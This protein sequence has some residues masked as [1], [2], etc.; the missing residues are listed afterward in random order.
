MSKKMKKIIAAVISITF[1]L[2]SVGIVY[3]ADTHEKT[4]TAENTVSISA[5]NTINTSSSGKDE[6]VYVFAGADGSTNKIIVSDWLKNPDGESS[7]KD[8]SELKNIENVKGDETFSLSGKEVTWNADG[9]D[10]YYQGEISKE[11]PISMNIKYTLDGKEVSPKELAGKS[12]HVVIRYEYTNNQLEKVELNGKEQEVYVPFAVLTGMVLDNDIFKN[13]EVT[14]G[15]LINDGNRSAVVG[16]AFPSLQE[17]LKI[18]KDKFEIPDYFE[19][20]ADV[21]NFSLTNTVTLATNEVFNNISFSKSDELSNLSDSMTKLSDAMTQLM[22]GSSKL[23]DGLDSLLTKSNELVSG[24]N[25]LSAGSDKLKNGVQSLSSGANTLS[26]GTKSLYSGLSELQSNSAELNAG[27]EQVFESLLSMAADQLNQAGLEVPELTISNYQTVLNSVLSGLNEDTVTTQ[28][29]AKVTAAVNAQRSAVEA[30][31]TEAVRAEVL[32]KVLASMNMTLEQYQQGVAAGVIT[33]A[34]QAQI[35]GAVDAQMS[36]DSVKAVISSK[37]DEQINMLIEQ[38]MQSADVQAQISQG[39]DSVNAGRNSITALIDQLNSY[40]EF[41]TGLSAYTSGVDSAKAGAEKLNTGAASLS[42]GA[43]D[44]SAGINE[45]N[46][47]IKKIKDNTP[48]LIDGVKQLRDG[49]KSLNEGIVKLNNDGITKLINAVDG[50]FSGLFERVD[51]TLQA[52]EKYRSFS[53]ITD[54]TNGTVKFVYRTE[55]IK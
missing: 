45:L 16:M 35:N 29:K 49:A 24:I 13:V 17:N 39:I 20:S 28:A 14:N 21:K 50:N 5:E 54:D 9:N 18:D 25:S 19:V 11:L 23:Y 53:G 22:D 32:G 2:S 46:N 34:Q 51:Y 38:N 40:N 7:L 31:V 30:K 6:T 8:F 27:A 48:A 3:A 41:Y 10:I 33:S 42:S 15:K 12:G 37:T 52:S 47:G 4:D 43:K 26:D 1:V 44:L 36:T 55:A